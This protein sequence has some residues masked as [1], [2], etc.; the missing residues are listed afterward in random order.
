MVDPP[1]GEAREPGSDH[2]RGHLEILGI[3]AGD[4]L[5]PRLAGEDRTQAAR[6]SACTSRWM[7]AIWGSP[8]VSVKNMRG[9]YG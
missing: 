4:P 1:H 6:A 7:A 5:G 3:G 2:L 9:A 8:V